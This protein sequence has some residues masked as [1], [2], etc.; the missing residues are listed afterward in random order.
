MLFINVDN[1]Y[2]SDQKK[3]I[4]Y[5]ICLMP[6]FTKSR[7]SMAV[8]RTSHLIKKIRK[9]KSLLFS[10]PVFT[11]LKLRYCACVGIFNYV[12]D[13]IDAKKNY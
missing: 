5:V 11:N 4:Y 7:S 1:L 10:T 2:I 13:T 8:C 6:K 9:N 3:L 12:I